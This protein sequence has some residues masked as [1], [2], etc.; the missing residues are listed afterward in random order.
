MS[1]HRVQVSRVRCFR[2]LVLCKVVKGSVGCDSEI[3]NKDC[4]GVLASAFELE[5]CR[6]GRDAAPETGSSSSDIDGAGEAGLV[7]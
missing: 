1:G 6:S 4:C 5:G 7:N 3:D 2:L